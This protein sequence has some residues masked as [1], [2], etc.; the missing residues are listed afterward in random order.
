[1]AA[2]GYELCSL[3]PAVLPLHHGIL[4]QLFPFVTHR[5][6]LSPGTMSSAKSESPDPPAARSE[7]SRLTALRNISS[8]W[9]LIPQG[10]GI[11]AVTLLQ[12]HY[13]FHGLRTIAL[14]VWAL[15]I[16]LFVSILFLYILRVIHFPK[17]FLSLLANDNT[18]V[19]CLAC[20]P[21]TFSSL[22]QMLSLVL[23]SDERWALA[24]YSL[25]WISM[26]ASLLALLAIPHSFATIN[27]PGYANLKPNS[28]LPIVAGLTCAAAGA[29][30]CQSA[31]L[32][33]TMQ[34]P[35]IIVSYLLVGISTPL[36]LFLDTLFF[37]RLLN[38]PKVVK[39][40]EYRTQALSL[41]CQ[42]AILIGPWS[43]G[44]SAL[45]SLGQSVLQGTFAQYDSGMLLT[46]QAAPA[47]GYFSMFAGLLCWGQ[48]FFW[49]VFT[50]ASLLYAGLGNK[51]GR[52]HFKFEMTA[53]CMV[54]PWVSRAKSQA[55]VE[56]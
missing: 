33:T 24:A 12:L 27:P 31:A 26:S 47:V 39:T 49:W 25:W 42:Q 55:L 5:S 19:A 36:A 2:L 46:S 22:I 8:V 30:I 3:A 52:V 23:G 43:Q 32:S 20:I 50:L 15:A 40:S 7:Q 11:L 17:Y 41:A 9:F 13:Q 4:R 21:V 38:Q 10:T 1:M 37:G 45:Q 48:A 56:G 35:I 44:S 34:M 28:Q 18:E 14:I 16:A 54:F 29:S 53:W 51:Q 6:D